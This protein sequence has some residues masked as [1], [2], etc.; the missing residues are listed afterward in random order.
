MTLTLASI[1]MTVPSIALFGALI[2]LLA[3][4]GMGVGVTP[5]IIALILYSQLPII[6][7]SMTG[8]RSVSPGVIKSARG[9]GLTPIQQLL[10][11]RL[12]LAMPLILSG[13]RIAVV[14]GVG[15]AAVAAYVGAGGLGRWIFGGIRRGYPE[16]LLSSA[17]LVSILAILLDRVLLGLQIF[18]SDKRT[19]SSG[20]D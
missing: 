4:L 8:L 11:V 15:V 20:D 19:L 9:L 3:P 16:M 17:L 14:M 10:K 6:R 18:F 12:P 5:A 7:N 13:I 1:I 2:P